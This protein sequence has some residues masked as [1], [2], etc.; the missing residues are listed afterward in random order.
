[1]V[2]FHK[3][4]WTLFFRFFYFLPT[5][6]LKKIKKSKNE[7]KIQI[8][9]FHWTEIRT[10]NS[11]IILKIV[12]VKQISGSEVISTLCNY[13]EERGKKNH[14]FEK[15]PNNRSM[16]ILDMFFYATNTFNG[17]KTSLA[18]F[19]SHENANFTRLILVPIWDED[20]LSD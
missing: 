9:K 17:E 11:D 14:H 20:F 4:L 18:F 15:V 1:M 8:K 6:L 12:F 19:I 5:L 7:K 16:R 10:F 13:T 3:V 2:K